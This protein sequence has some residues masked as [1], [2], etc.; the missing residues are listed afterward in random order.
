ML[1]ERTKTTAVRVGLMSGQFKTGK[2]ERFSPYLPDISLISRVGTGLTKQQAITMLRAEDVAYIAFA[3]RGQNWASA[4][5]RRQG[6]QVRVHV[7][8]DRSFLVWALKDELQNQLGFYGTPVDIV[9]PFEEIFFYRHGMNLCE[10]A[11]PLSEL[12]VDRGVAQKNQISEGRSILDDLMN[13]PIGEILGEKHN[14][15]DEI[16]K[17]AIRSQK[18]KQLRI[19]EVLI[20]LGVVSTK[21]V[22]IALEEQRKN[23]R[24][25]LG[26]VLVELGLVKEEDLY[27]VLAQ[28]FHLPFADLDKYAVNMEAAR[29]IEPDILHEYRVYPVDID[30]TSITIATCDPTNTQAIEVIRSELN[31]SVREVIATSSQIKSYLERLKG[32][33]SQVVTD[34]ESELDLVEELHESAGASDFDDILEELDGVE[35]E[36]EEVDDESHLSREDVSAIVRLVNRILTDAHHQGASDIHIEPY[37]RDARVIVR[38]RIDGECRIYQEIPSKYRKQLVARIKIMSRLD[39]SERRLPQDGKIRFR[40]KD[41]WIEFR[42]AT[43]P[44]V[45]DNEDVV[46][47]LLASSE[48]IPLDKMGL[49]ERNLDGIKELISRP[50]GL[51]LCVGPTG[52]GKTTTLHSAI[53]AINT[54]D[55]KIWTAEDPVEITQ[56]GLRQVQMQPKIGLT[57]ANALRAFLRADPDV[58]MV[59]EMRDLETANIAVEASLTGHLVFSTL[60]TNS[61]PE[62]VTRLL[63]MEIDPFSFADALLGVLA[64][65]LVRRLCKQCRTLEKASQKQLAQLR[66]I[67]GQEAIDRHVAKSRFDELHVFAPKGCSRCSGGYKG[68]L[69]IHELL[70]NTEELRS[71]IST[72]AQAS[73]IRD[74]A[75]EDG[76]TLLVEDGIKKALEGHTDLSQIFAV[77]GVG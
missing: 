58:I 25:Q 49:S 8:G 67:I 17:R 40:L 73:I 30:E 54:S 77:C 68:R 33:P 34:L 71:L 4:S 76:M 26:D 3:R 75:V 23:K 29:A 46:L 44:T 69:A 52:S 20:E 10:D 51:L 48:P 59:G 56:K 45:N 47:R 18:E 39:I 28:K 70:M 60:H 24:L 5:G 37:G 1:K 57:F 9:V 62:T 21:D 2:L 38:F 22:E 42:V 16:I 19:G 15:D 41:Q 74:K 11:R 6:K 64:Q 43:I 31:L 55:K 35:D 36:T 13:R 12:L 27:Q 63:D 7:A 50:H 61:A 72:K 53:G 32:M 65:R 14:I 66:S